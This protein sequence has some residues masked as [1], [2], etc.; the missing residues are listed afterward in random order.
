MLSA[1]THPPPREDLPRSEGNSADHSR[2]VTVPI[3]SS[4]NA[5]ASPYGAQFLDTMI[6]DHEAV[7]NI[8]QLAQTR[9]GSSDLKALVRMMIARQ[10]AEIK[11][12]RGL[13]EI[14]AASAPPSVNIDL[15]GIKDGVLTLD[16][17]KLDVLKEDGFDRELLIEMIRHHTGSIALLTD[18]DEKLNSSGADDIRAFIRATATDRRSELEQ[19]KKL[20]ASL[21]R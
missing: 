20:Q 8:A 14:D 13:R 19:M 6:A 3:E 9:A 10:Q 15:P 12:M 16:P 2:T 7:L 17:D 4:P 5:A 21:P 1:C 11:Q 18:A